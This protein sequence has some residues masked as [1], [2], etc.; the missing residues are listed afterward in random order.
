M[1]KMD[2]IHKCCFSD[3]DDQSCVFAMPVKDGVQCKAIGN[4]WNNWNVKLLDQCFIKM[5]A[6]QKLM[7]R[8]R[9]L[10][11]KARN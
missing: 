9:Q 1:Q 11:K 10:K 5:R 6:R 8:N 7:W 4:W 2:F 3:Q